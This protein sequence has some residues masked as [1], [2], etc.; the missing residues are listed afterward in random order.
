MSTV[1]LNHKVSAA[2]PALRA[3]RLFGAN[4][5]ACG[6]LGCTEPR[7]TTSCRLP[8]VLKQQRSRRLSGVFLQ[9]RLQCRDEQIGVGFRKYQRG[10]QLDDIVMRPVGSSQNSAIPQAVDN[11]IRCCG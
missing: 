2:L 4:Q 9:D 1:A 6:G 11:V 5:T 10:P 3:L 8:Y 7:P